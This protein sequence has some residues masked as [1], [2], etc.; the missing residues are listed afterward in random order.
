MSAVTNKLSD[1]ERTRYFECKD[2]V[3]ENLIAFFDVG[4]ALKEIRDNR[5]Y[6]EDFDTFEAFCSETYKMKRAQAYRLIAA[7]EIKAE[8]G[9]AVQNV[10][11]ATA[12]AKVPKEKRGAVLDKAAKT[13]PVTAKSITES[14]KPAAQVELDKTGF[15]IP[16]KLLPLWERSKEVQTILTAVSRIRTALRTAQEQDD[17]LWRP[18]AGQGKLG[19]WSRLMSNMDNTYSTLSQAVPFAVCPTCQGHL[20]KDCTVCQE[21]GFVSEFYYKNCLD[22]DSKK[23]RE[24][25]CRKSK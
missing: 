18:I 13:G 14:A 19:S 23:V 20:A 12:L 3:R 2:T 1:T 5:L 7:A 4:D 9:D 22:G 16:A 17:P 15:A 8:A 6:R 11:Q 21:R 25:V 10:A 24:A